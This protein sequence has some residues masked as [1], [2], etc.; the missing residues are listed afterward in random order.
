MPYD[1]PDMTDPMEMIGVELPAEE[2]AME[3]LA[4]VFA[5][6]FA[7]MGFDERKLLHLFKT[8]F[9]AG[10]HNAYLALGEEKIQEIVRASLEVWGRIRFLDR[11]ADP[12]SGMILL[13]V[14]PV[15]KGT[16]NQHET[17]DMEPCQED[18]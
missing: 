10:A 5:E 12:G 15:L 9:Y 8:P 4:R 3:E 2:P 1:D 13:P 17:D 16:D 7:R 18:Q 11:E 14:L 6:E